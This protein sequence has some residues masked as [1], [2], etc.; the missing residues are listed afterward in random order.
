M[1]AGPPTKLGSQLAL[2]PVA[3]KWVVSIVHELMAGKK[4]YNELRRGCRGFH[5]AC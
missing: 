4:R 1:D 3:D 2:E 5:S